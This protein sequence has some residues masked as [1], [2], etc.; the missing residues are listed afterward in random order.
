MKRLCK[1]D[2][3]ASK[4]FCDLG[5]GEHLRLVMDVEARQIQM[6][7]KARRVILI[8]GYQ[9]GESTLICL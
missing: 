4:R 2:A 3:L 8:G 7:V 1:E 5:E 6:R 9:P